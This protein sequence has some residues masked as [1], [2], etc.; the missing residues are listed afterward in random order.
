MVLIAH[1]QAMIAEGLAAA[2][3]RWPAICPVGAVASTGEVERFAGRVDAVALDE[4]LHD[5]GG[6]TQRLRRRGI[7]V[8]T[9]CEDSMDEG[10][11]VSLRQPIEALARALV[12]GA[13]TPKALTSNLTAR[14][15]EILTLAA[16]GLAAKQVARVLSISPKTVE[17]HK[18]RIFAKLGVANQTAAVSLAL[19]TTLALTTGR[20]T[21]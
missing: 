4:R 10:V 21:P 11:R 19:G 18:T 20:S 12:P 17:Q 7:R 2:L 1:S 3:Q 15:R 16:Q 9:I 14:E 6:A 13:V 8:V 5:V